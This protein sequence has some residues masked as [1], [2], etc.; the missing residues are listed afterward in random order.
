MPVTTHICVCRTLGPLLCLYGITQ[1]LVEDQWQSQ[2]FA[3]ILSKHH[4]IFISSIDEKII[5]E[6]HM[7]PAKS[8]QEA[9]NKADEILCKEMAKVTFIPEGITSIIE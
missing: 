4:V 6:M 1:N 3:R 2:I 5:K 9:L 8:F 7:I